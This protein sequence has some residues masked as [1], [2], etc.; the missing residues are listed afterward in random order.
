MALF[1]TDFLTAL[2]TADRVHVNNHAVSKF[3]FIGNA[4]AVVLLEDGDE[5][6]IHRQVVKV[7]NGLSSCRSEDFGPPHAVDF[8]MYGPRHMSES[9]LP[10]KVT[11]A[12]EE[13][14]VGEP[15]TKAK[16][17][18]SRKSPAGNKRPPARRRA[19]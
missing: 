3:H 8:M 1:I 4:L 17:P 9:D 18:R 6:R 19:N 16:P 7:I 10:Q 5:L 13:S 15:T 2:A 14:L 11:D 12:E